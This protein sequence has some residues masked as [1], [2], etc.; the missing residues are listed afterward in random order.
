[1]SNDLGQR[2]YQHFEVYTARARR[3][4]VVSPLIMFGGNCWI[5]GLMMAPQACRPA[6]DWVMA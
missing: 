6:N 4:G 3:S 1:M 2:W 5:P